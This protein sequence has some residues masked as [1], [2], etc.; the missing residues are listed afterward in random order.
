LLCGE[1]ENAFRRLQEEIICSITDLSIFAWWLGPI[2]EGLANMT[3]VRK[4]ALETSLC[5]I[6]AKDPVYFTGSNMVKRMYETNFTTC[7]FQI[8]VSGPKHPYFVMVGICYRWI[9][10]RRLTE[11]DLAYKLQ[12][13]KGDIYESQS[14]Q[15]S[16]VHGR[17]WGGPTS[18][19]DVSSHLDAFAAWIY[20]VPAISSCMEITACNARTLV[21]DQITSRNTTQG[22]LAFGVVGR[23]RFSLLH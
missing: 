21:A 1:E 11:N 17:Y 13:W 12:G 16:R 2:E 4:V 22:D 10:T 23:G 6:L 3:A 20:R 15:S 9:A 7:Q 5:G 8:S 18:D 14:L 19:G